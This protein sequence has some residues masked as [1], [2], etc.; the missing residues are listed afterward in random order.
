MT[1]RDPP[2]TVQAEFEKIRQRDITGLVETSEIFPREM[3]SIT[4]GASQRLHVL[5][6]VLK[7]RLAHRTVTG[8]RTFAGRQDNGKNLL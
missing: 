8:R 7:Y 4:R 5:T 3:L 1:E 2:E 6:T